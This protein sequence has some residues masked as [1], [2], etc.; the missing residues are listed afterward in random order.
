MNVYFISGM[1]TDRSA[2][3]QIKLP[4]QFSIHHL[5]WL[6]PTKD[7]S[8]EAYSRRMAA[9]IDTSKPFAIVGLSFGG[10][11][12]SIISTFLKPAKTI[13]LSSVGSRKEMP[14]LF[15]IAGRLHLY[16]LIP[17]YLL[18]HPNKIA[19]ALFGAKNKEKIMLASIM[20]D[21]D[22]ALLKWSIKAML[23][24]KQD[25]KE[26]NIYHIHGDKDSI[27]PVKYTKPTMIIQNGTHFM[28]WTKGP[29]VSKA[30]TEALETY[31]QE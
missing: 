1:G 7:E 23:T 19:F 10:V 25:K 12:A 13:L 17:A 16:K 15:K 21:A 14:I 29:E 26:S 31:S 28:V 30:I 11:I 27:L 6:T 18:K 2:F 4:A 8:L 24:W 22:V 9:G 3:G 20:S 5:D